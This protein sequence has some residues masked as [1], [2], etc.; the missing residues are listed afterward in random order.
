MNKY[1]VF[2][3]KPDAVIREIRA[4][5]SR[6]ISEFFD[7]ISE[8]EII[9]DREMVLRQRQEEWRKKWNPPPN[10]E[11]KEFCILSEIGKEVALMC[12]IK[13]KN[14]AIEF[15]KTLRGTHPLPHLCDKG[16]LRR[17]YM[18]ESILDKIEI[19]GRGIGYL[20]DSTGKRIGFVPNII[21]TVDN[22]NE[23][24]EHLEEFFSDIDVT[25]LK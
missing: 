16:S 22:E 19:D 8:R 4:A 3:L 13:T 9:R 6:D 10:E 7:I 21:H 18:D 11:Q 1:T 2:V 24:E 14:D 17:K 12:R 5:I 15:G 20:C 25:E 23:L